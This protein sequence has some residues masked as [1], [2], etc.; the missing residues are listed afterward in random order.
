MDTL[1]KLYTVVAENIHRARERKPWQETPPSKLRVNDLVLVKDPE[2]GAFDP[3]YM[4]NYRVTAVYGRNRIGLQDEKGN[5]SV[6]CAAHV[7]I[8]EPVDKA[9][10]QLPPQSVYEQYGRVS[11]L[12]IH[13]KDVPQIPLELFNE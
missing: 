5:K 10:S 9:I 12:L 8:C 13:P 6:R 7:K 1:W 2:S 11:K 4:P 3:R